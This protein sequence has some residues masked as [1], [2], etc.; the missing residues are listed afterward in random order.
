MNIFEY[1]KT[2][3]ADY[4]DMNTGFIY[5]V[6][7]YNRA[8]KLGLSINFIEVYDSEGNYIGNVKEA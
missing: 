6:Q 4:M 2:T 1:A 5:Q 7:D 3:D 8:K